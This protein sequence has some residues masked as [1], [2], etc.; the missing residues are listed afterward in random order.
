MTCTRSDERLIRPNRRL[1]LQGLG[2]SG[3]LGFTGLIAGAP[4]ARA[5]VRAVDLLLVLAVDCSYSVSRTEYNLQTQGLAL[6]FLDPEIVEACTAGPNQQIAVAVMQWSSE[7]SQV[8]SIPWQ[9]INSV[10]AAIQFSARLSTMPRET[11]DGA[12]AMGDALAQAGAYIQTAPF[13][14]FRRV[15]DVSADGRKNTGSVVEPVRDA[16]VSR[17]VTI[18]G[19]AILNEDPTLDYYFRKA[20]IGGVGAFAMV[21]NDYQEYGTAIRKK[22]LREIRFV[23]VSDATDVVDPNGAQGG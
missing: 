3:S 5:Q 9:V 21:A 14:A 19:L 13:E 1:L 17:G 8:F 16:L 4:Q 15:I 2:L 6:A 23:P 10:Q 7:N 11:A 20:L 22:L 18:N 12:T